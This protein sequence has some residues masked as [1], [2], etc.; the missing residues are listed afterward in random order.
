MT[1]LIHPY[2]T[3]YY[4]VQD[5]LIQPNGIIKDLSLVFGLSKKQLK[6]YI[7][8]WV[9]KQ[10]RGFDFNKC[11]KSIDYTHII[12]KSR[13]IKAAWT[14]IMASDVS[15]IPGFNAEAEL[16][17]IFIESIHEEMRNLVQE[18][19]AINNSMPNLEF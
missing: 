4:R 19:R 10:N 11:W 3:R 13:R 18:M 12:S 14:Q 16:T 6:F 7:K 17:S 2:L 8:G 5:D 1:N 9:R 15:R